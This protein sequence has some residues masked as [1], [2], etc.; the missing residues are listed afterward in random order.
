MATATF[1]GKA[2]T[3]LEM[4]K[5]SHT[6]FA[7]PFALMGATLAALASGAPPTA[8]QVGWICLA[9]VGARS[10]AMGLNRLIDAGIDAQNPRT[11]S[12][13]IPAG[14]VSR[15]EAWLFIAASTALLLWAAWRLNPLCLA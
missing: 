15:G 2:K 10:A 7:F 9:M 13:H 3:M 14:K 12:R 8:A 1:F 4:I 6:V 5:F 11:A